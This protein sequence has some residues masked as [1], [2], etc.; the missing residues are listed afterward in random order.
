MEWINQFVS[1][2]LL[3]Q[4]GFWVGL[5]VL[6]ASAIGTRMPSI[7]KNKVYNAI[8]KVLNVIALNVG[9]NKNADAE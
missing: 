6:V 7:G 5:V 2:G 3:E 8:M 4:I 1:A 9:K